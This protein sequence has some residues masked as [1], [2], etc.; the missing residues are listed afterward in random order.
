MTMDTE[1]VK[2]ASAVAA[3][4]AVDSVAAV[5]A[6]LVAVTAAAAAGV[7][8]GVSKTSGWP[9]SAISGSE[10]STSPLAWVPL[11]LALPITASVSDEAEVRGYEAAL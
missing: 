6:V 1:P 8:G 11:L 4:A 3:A 5:V 9:I 10:S 2:L 7:V